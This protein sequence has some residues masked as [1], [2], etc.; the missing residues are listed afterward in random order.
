MLIPKSVHARKYPDGD[1]AAVG[2]HDFLE[3]SG[4]GLTHVCSRL[5]V[6]FMTCS[7][8]PMVTF[9]TQPKSQALLIK[10]IGKLRLYSGPKHSFTRFSATR[11]WAWVISPWL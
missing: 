11:I 2:Y 8:I 3:G 4:V 10:R 7:S 9:P 6:H 5:V 1:F